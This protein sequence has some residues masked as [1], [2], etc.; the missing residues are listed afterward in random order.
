MALKLSPFTA[1]SHKVLSFAHPQMAGLRSPKFSMASTLRSNSNEAKELKKLSCASSMAPEKV[2]LFK[3]IEDWARDSILPLL[4]P[5]EKSWQPGDLLP[6][7]GSDG[8]IEQINEIR[9]RTKE[10]PDD[11]LVA[12]VGNMITEEALPT[13][14]SRI[15]AIE[16]YHDETGTDNNPWA[17]WSR[18]WS[19]E[20][21][22]HGDLLNKYLYLSGRIDIKQVEKTIQHLIASGM[23][24]GT[25]DNPYHWTIY[26][27]FQE[28][29]TFISHGNTAKLAMKHGDSKLAQICG[30]IAADEKRH[31]TAYSRIVGKLFELDP[32]EAM[33]AFADMLKI[34]ITMPGHLMYDGQDVHLFDHYS[35]VAMR[36]GVYTTSDYISVLEH[37]MGFWNVKKLEGLSSEGKIAQD[38]VCELPERLRKIEERARA[39]AIKAPAIPFSWVYDREV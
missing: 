32:S 17:I 37:L 1:Q 9:E 6:D 25:G 29:A 31:E 2:E 19:A 20:E 15:N 16:I 11:C 27:S 5:V 4:K 26:T 34:K 24:F 13:Y 18:A 21:N 33:V 8:F 30:T 7:S 35:N 10:I 23:D 28:R 39:R 22:R 3:S 12:L 36:I 14:Q 38:Y